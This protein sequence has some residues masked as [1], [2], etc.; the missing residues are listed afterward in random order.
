MIGSL[1][2]ARIPIG[3][4]WRTTTTR[5]PAPLREACD[6]SKLRDELYLAGE[7]YGEISRSYK[8]T[9]DILGG[10]DGVTLAIFGLSKSR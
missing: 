10:L 4:T 6:R 9:I 8:V 3:G 5:R 7:Q 2:P 1:W